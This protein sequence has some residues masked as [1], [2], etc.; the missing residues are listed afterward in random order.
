MLRAALL[1]FAAS[2][3]AAQTPHFEVATLKL[4]PPPE[5]DQIFT[6]LGQFSGNRLILT[7]ARLSDC[8]KFAYGIVADAQLSGPDWIQSRAIRF[9]IVGQT[10]PNTTRSEALL[11][12]QSLLAE[13][14]NVAIHH[15]QRE[16][17][18]LALVPAKSGVK[19]K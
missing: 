12:L 14:L 11:M 6:N 13:R 15:E 9:D 16:L 5:S 10:P 3:A 17:S 1:L 2:V 18:Y 19:M 4:S 7:N 8:L